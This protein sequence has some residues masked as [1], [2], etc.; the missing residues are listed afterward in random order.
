MFADLATDVRCVSAGV[1]V[2]SSTRMTGIGGVS[3][4]EHERVSRRQGDTTP[5]NRLS[6]V[7]SADAETLIYESSSACH[8]LSS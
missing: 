7:L 8:G 2:G 3:C 1:P 5:G 6:S 4:C